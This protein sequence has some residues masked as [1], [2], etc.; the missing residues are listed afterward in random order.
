MMSLL[1]LFSYLNILT[2]QFSV[3]LRTLSFDSSTSSGLIYFTE[4]FEVLNFHTI[5]SK[6]LFRK[7]QNMNYYI[8]T[9]LGIR[10]MMVFKF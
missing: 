2:P 4:E 3:Y 8:P 1:K 7:V 6:P 9:V 5:L 10:A